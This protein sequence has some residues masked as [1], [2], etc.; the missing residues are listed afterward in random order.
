MN[1]SLLTKKAAR[2]LQGHTKRGDRPARGTCD[3]SGFGK[4]LSPGRVLEPPPPR[5][6]GPPSPSRPAATRR[7]GVLPL[8]P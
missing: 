4:V 2:Q 7:S 1:Y 8:F 3:P 6:G 5:P